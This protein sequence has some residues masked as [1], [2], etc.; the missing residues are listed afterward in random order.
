MSDVLVTRAPLDLPRAAAIS[1]DALMPVQE[2]VSGAPMLALPLKDLLGRL[3]QT[4]EA[5]AT[6]AEL[7][8]ALAYP[9]N[10]IGLV[11]A[12]PDPEK[13]GWYRKTGASDAGEWVQFEILSSQAIPTVTALAEQVANDREEA[14]TARDIAVAAAALTGGVV[15]LAVPGPWIASDKIGI[16][17]GGNVQ[18]AVSRSPMIFAAS[19]IGFTA[20]MTSAQFN[21]AQAAV[22][23]KW[24]GGTIMFDLDIAV[25]VSGGQIIKP[26]LIDWTATAKGATLYPSVGGALFVVAQG[27][28]RVFGKLLIDGR[29]LITTTV[30]RFDA[31]SKIVDVTGLRASCEG[32]VTYTG[33]KAADEAALAAV[34]SSVAAFLNC[35]A[36]ETR[37][38]VSGDMV[39]LT[40]FGCGNGV[41]FSR[42]SENIKAVR[43]TVFAY[44]NRGFSGRGTATAKMA[45]SD[46][47]LEDCTVGQGLVGAGPRYPVSFYRDGLYRPSEIHVHRLRLVLGGRPHR[48]DANRPL[49][50]GASDAI[51]FHGVNNGSIHDTTVIGAGECGITI[52]QGCWDVTCLRNTICSGETACISVGPAGEQNR[53]ITVMDNTARMSSVD[54]GNDHGAQAFILFSNVDGLVYGGNKIIQP[55]MCNIENVLR[56]NPAIIQV[57]GEHD[58]I[59]G[60][61][62][63]VAGVGG[64]TAAN[65]TWR[66]HETTPSTV[67]LADLEGV[68]VD[69]TAWA[70]YTSG[71]TIAPRNDPIAAYN[72]YDS[73]ATGGGPVTGVECRD[74]GEIE[75]RIPNVKVSAIT[76]ANPAVATVGGTNSFVAGNLIRLSGSTVTAWNGVYRVRAKTSTTITLADALTG[77]DLDATALAAFTGTAVISI[78]PGQA[79]LPYFSGTAMWQT[80]GH[81]VEFDVLSSTGAP[82]STVPTL[83]AFSKTSTGVYVYDFLI[84]VR[85]ARA[86]VLNGTVSRVAVAEKTGPKQVTVRTGNST[87]G[88]ALDFAFTLNVSD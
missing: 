42:N 1:A 19:G 65:A 2:P 68:P 75:A 13:C 76:S 73:S 35:N 32:R 3:I 81:A 34:G 48:A 54:L 18:D 44:A 26:P 12:D 7:Q 78:M 55:R 38:K 23:A 82:N 31:N 6:E 57:V 71:G 37:D 60:D 10:T 36:V 52:A 17:G 79:T 63:V 84:P 77:L 22:I 66:V 47:K 16:V 87:T 43:C 30:F 58:F 9:A 85:I 4:S 45:V 27:D 28:V 80:R 50:N 33:E 29:S 56:E 11:F 86:T 14:L 15:D 64:A 39:G 8:A 67:T 51:N 69:G 21:A 62:V 72:F 20:A 70:A 83:S 88:A 40:A 46:I 59:V 41:Q 25:D 61:P 24:G 74:F 5:T 49:T 53:R